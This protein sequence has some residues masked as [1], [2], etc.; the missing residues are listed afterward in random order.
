MTRSQPHPLHRKA[1]PF[2]SR[3]HVL[4]A[5]SE[6]GALHW[7]LGD[8]PTFPKQNSMRGIPFCKRLSVLKPRGRQG[9]IEAKHIMSN[10]I[11]HVVLNGRTDFNQNHKGFAQELKDSNPTLRGFHGVVPHRAASH[12]SLCP[13]VFQKTTP[14]PSTAQH[15]PETSGTRGMQLSGNASIEQ[16]FCQSTPNSSAGNALPKEILLGGISPT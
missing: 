1:K 8:H 16:F 5:Q 7:G 13:K 2:L 3:K 6:A 14:P 4:S 11:Q 12:T 10:L 9:G 15:C